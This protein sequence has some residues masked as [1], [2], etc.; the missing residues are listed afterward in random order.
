LLLKIEQNMPLL[1][2][3]R[4]AYTYNDMPMELRRGYYLTSTH[5]YRNELN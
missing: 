2:I 4:V 5:H 3:E 1:S